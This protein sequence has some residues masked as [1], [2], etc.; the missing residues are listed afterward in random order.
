[1]DTGKRL[2]LNLLVTLEVLLTE[3]NVSRAARRLHLSQPAV[4]AQ[5]AR[6]RQLLDD[7]L[8]LP[9]PRGMRPTERAQALLAPLRQSLDAVRATVQQARDFDPR[10]AQLDVA[11]ACTDYL[12][13]AL[14]LPLLPH[15]RALAP[16]VRL[17]MYNLKPGDTL[18]QQMEQGV[19]DIALMQPVDAPASLRCRPLYEEHYVLVGR[20]GHRKLTRA[21]GVAQFAALEQVV[22]SVEGGRFATP[23][24]AQLAALGLSRRVAVSAASF[25][26]VPEIVAHSDLV[27]LLPSR[28]LGTCPN[29]LK[30]VPC[31]LPVPPFTVAML[32]H[33]RSHTHPGQRWLRDFIVRQVGDEGCWGGQ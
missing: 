10:T 8:L 31:P 23:V 4:S 5:L 30:V 16:G 15:L 14:L 19:V 28:L 22:V 12:Q 2:D 27:A 6:L 29:A 24:D 25:S 32:W 3:Q 13:R 1:M 33:E 9:A 18:Q 20:K 26:V 17:A 11:I 21:L 7:P